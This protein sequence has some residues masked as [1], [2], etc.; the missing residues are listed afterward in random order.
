MGFLGSREGAGPEVP[1]THL[2]E[3]REAVPWDTDM[4]GPRTWVSGGSGGQSPKS[5]SH[6]YGDPGDS[7]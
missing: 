1:G 2:W 4:G 5:E 6:R 7:A 3:D